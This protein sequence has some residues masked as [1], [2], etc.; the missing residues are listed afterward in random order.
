MEMV[1]VQCKCKGH[2][3]Y[4]ENKRQS[5]SMRWIG[6]WKFTFLKIQ[7]THIKRHLNFNQ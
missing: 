5:G 4:N 3:G 2:N 6:M 1:E 7:E